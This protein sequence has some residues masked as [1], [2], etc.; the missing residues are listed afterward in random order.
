[1]LSI[2]LYYPY[3]FI[4]PLYISLSDFILYPFYLPELLS[5][6][7]LPAGWM[8]RDFN[9]CVVAAEIYAAAA[10]LYIAKMR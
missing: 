4:I 8:R 10:D 2:S 6:S 9:I 5:I 1:M 3:V 7:T